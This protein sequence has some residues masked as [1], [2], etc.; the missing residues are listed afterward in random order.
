M[1]SPPDPLAARLDGLPAWRV[2]ALAGGTVAVALLAVVLVA[3][4]ADHTAP[5]SPFPTRLHQALVGLPTVV[6]LYE[7]ARRAVLRVPPSWLLAGRP[8]RSVGRRTAAGFVFPV[9]VLAAHLWLLDASRVGVLPPA[10]S[11]VVFLLA[12]VAAGVLAGLLEELVFRGALLRLLE[13][14][15][16]AP[17]ALGGTTATFAVLHQGHAASAGELALVLSSMLAAC[18]LLGIVALRTRSVWNA[19]AVHA[20]WNTTFGGRLVDVGGPEEVL[21]R[22]VLQFRLQETAPMLTG[23]GATLASAPLTTGL[24]LLAA[25]AVGRFGPGPSAGPMAAGDGARWD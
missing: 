17:A 2:L 7:G 5:Y 16:G 9:G 11:V 25:V 23:G 20:G 3:L 13:A 12:S 19:V 1:S 8:D 18:L 24:L 15:W 6:V 22:A 14:R 21:E 4:L 10:G